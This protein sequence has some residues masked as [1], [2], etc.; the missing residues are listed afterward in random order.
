MTGNTNTLGT[1]LTTDGHKVYLLAVELAFGTE[2]DYAMLV[3]MYGGD[4]HKEEARYSPPDYI[5]CRETTVIGNPKP[6]DI[7]TS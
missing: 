4:A 2:V 5:G 7:S 3:K 6:K 1:Q